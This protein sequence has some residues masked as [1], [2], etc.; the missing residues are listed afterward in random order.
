M[1]EEEIIKGNYGYVESVDGMKYRITEVE[2]DCIHLIDYNGNHIC[3]DIGNV[4]C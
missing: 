4:N 1:T 3:C 2:D